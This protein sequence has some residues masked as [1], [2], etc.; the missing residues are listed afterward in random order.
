[1]GRCPGKWFQAERIASAKAARQGQVG[2]SAKERDDQEPDHRSFFTW[3]AH[4]FL[5]SLQKYWCLGPCPEILRQSVW[6]FGSGKRNSKW[7]ECSSPV[8]DGGG[9]DQ[10][11]GGGKAASLHQPCSLHTA[12][13]W[14]MGSVH[15]LSLDKPKAGCSPADSLRRI[16]HQRLSVLVGDPLK[17]LLDRAQ[18]RGVGRHNLFLRNHHLTVSN[19]WQPSLIMSTWVK[20]SVLGHSGVCHSSPWEVASLSSCYSTSWDRVFI[21]VVQ[22]NGN[23]KKG[24][25]RLIVRHWFMWLIWWC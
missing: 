4:I 18:G 12:H 17:P 11:S 10:G 6:G 16:Q 5:G 22:R 2:P 3:A 24:I 7:D 13:L 19:L 25:H 8:R 21:G 9:V 15:I 14:S 1:M 23:H 20:L